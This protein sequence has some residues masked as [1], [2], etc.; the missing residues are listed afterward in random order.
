MAHTI[1][2]YVDHVAY[3]RSKVQHIVGEFV[4]TLNPKWNCFEPS[5]REG[6][7][8]P[9]GLRG[10]WINVEDFRRQAEK[11]LGSDYSVTVLLKRKEEAEKALASGSGF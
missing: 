3:A 7:T 9:A 5:H 2:S 4:L 1:E 10:R 6:L 8:V 11:L